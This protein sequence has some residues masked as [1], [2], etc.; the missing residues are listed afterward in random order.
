MRALL[1]TNEPD[2][3]QLP[4]AYRI[5]PRVQIESGPLPIDQY[6]IKKAE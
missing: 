1:M 5:A 6:R 2:F 3:I 4:D